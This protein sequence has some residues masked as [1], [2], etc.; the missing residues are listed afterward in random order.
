MNENELLERLQSIENVLKVLMV[1]SILNGTEIDRLR[2]EALDKART[3]L[4][5]FDFSNLRLNYIEDKYFIFAESKS[6][7]SAS[8]IRKKY[9]A[10]QEALGGEKLVL[11]FDKL[12]SK[13][14]KAIEDSEI[15][16]FIAG[17]TL[18]IFEE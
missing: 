4:E 16:Y 1:N 5:P 15:S 18:K 7:D 14:K 12:N 9:F 3:R 10:A 8:V 17:K 13:T 6:T 11:V 2:R